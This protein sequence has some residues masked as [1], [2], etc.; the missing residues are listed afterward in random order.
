MIQSST[1]PAIRVVLTSMI[2]EIATIPCRILLVLDDYH[3]IETQPIHEALD[4][5]L[6]NLPQQM[7][8][9]IVTR[10]DPFLQLSGLRARDQLTEL[11]A[12]DMRFFSSETAEF[13]N[14]VMGLNLSAENID[15][16]ESRTEGWIAGLQ[17]AA[18]SIRGEQAPKK[19]I[20]SFTGSHRLVLDYLIEEVLERQSE[21]I[22]IFLLQTSILEQ[23]NGS[24]CD[25]LTGEVDGQKTLEMLEGANL[26][27]VP[28]DNERRW[29][30]YHH[31][32]ADLLRQRLHQT[33]PEMI[34]MLHS[35]ASE[36]FETND[37]TDKAVEYSLQAD[38]FI[39]AARLMELAWQSMSANF[40]FST[41]LCWA[42]KLPDDLI[43]TRPVLCAQYAG[44]LLESGELEV[45]ESRFQEAE[46]WLE[47]KTDVSP[48][49]EKSSYSMVV[50]EEDQFR[51][52]PASI[53][54]G[55]AQIAL[56]RGDITGAMN[57]AELALRLSPDESVINSQG[58]VLLGMT[59]WAGGDL[60]AAYRSMADWVNKMQRAG[61]IYFAVA[62]SFG[63]ADIRIAQG[64]LCE[65]E[66]TYKQFL[67]LASEQDE[68]IKG[69]TAHHH[70]GLAM[71]YH[72]KYDLDAF[73]KHL[74]KSRELGEKTTLVDWP[75][76]W[77]LAQARL[78]ATERNWAA[79]LYQ[80]DE[81]RRLHVRNLV[82]DLQPIEALKARVYINQGLL[83]KAK[84]WVERRDI[85][86]DDNL[87]YMSEFEHITLARFSIAV[88]KGNNLESNVNQA[89]RLLKCLL[90]EAEDKSR[91]GS[92]IEILVVLSL[93]YEAQ[94][95]ISSALIHLEKALTLAESEGYI[96]IF[97]NEGTPM[98]HLLYE[99]FSQ[100][101]TPNYVRS[102]LAAFSDIESKKIDSVQLRI[103]KSDGVEP[104]SERETEVL[105]LISEGMTNQDIADRLYLSLHTVKGHARNI[106]GKL[107]VNNRTQAVARGK[108]LGILLPD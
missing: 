96:H 72:E 104:I 52:L 38:N 95:D 14:H 4:F 59:N 26:F 36:W 12:A 17:L 15:A 91:M 106:Y 28:L 63:L 98:A 80:L 54:I 68:S 79:V 94:A 93:A 61:N 87:S 10:E 18:L 84:N 102:L 88:Y 77:H 21:N 62:S 85:S 69:I 47:S 48:W 76:R 16:L 78:K 24:L 53:A 39:L 83:T 29:Y 35:Q 1:P 40:Q 57:F 46:R 33:H 100:D 23:L 56:S 101:I 71:I 37:F 6:N 30:R 3:R 34:P 105:Q 92:V 107:G 66:S 11:R 49:L 86:F 81:A 20:E 70:L 58:S 74:N 44:A 13:L 42:K 25:A 64:R 67:K 97:V 9:V 2:N 99:A 108:I 7:H 60:E 41:W 27:I 55:R 5:L 8:L 75:Y 82:P 90:I 32:F 51:T 45:S 65:A 43:R 19:F 73:T 103:T 89:I 31:L 22:Q 50:L